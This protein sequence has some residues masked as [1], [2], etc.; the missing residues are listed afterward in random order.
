M[1][2]ETFAANDGR[3][4]MSLKKIIAIIVIVAI[5]AIAAKYI[6]K[7]GA[8][9]DVAQQQEE[10]VALLQQIG[11]RMMLPDEQPI[12]ATVNEAA[13]LISEQAFYAGVQDGDKLVIFPRSQ[14]AVL[15]SPSRE[16]IVNAGPFIINNSTGANS[17]QN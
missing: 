9:D 12:V 16:I 4:K 5:I 15:Y 11:S 1:E 10:T 2:N 6:M 13:K 7:M 3:K 14:K 17:E 8:G